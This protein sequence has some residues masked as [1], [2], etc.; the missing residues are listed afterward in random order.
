LSNFPIFANSDD[1][2]VK[3]R[4]TNSSKKRPP[5][6]NSDLTVAKTSQEN[7]RTVRKDEII[8]TEKPKVN[9]TV[10]NSETTFQKI[11]SAEFLLQ[12][13]PERQES[14]ELLKARRGT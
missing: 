9:L 12:K 2:I 6:S 4:N 11:N 5:I 13:R 14:N 3:T 7:L 1:K 10:S 8:N